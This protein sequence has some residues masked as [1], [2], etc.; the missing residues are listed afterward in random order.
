[1][2]GLTPARFVAKTLEEIRSELEADYRAALGAGVDT[3]AESVRTRWPIPMRECCA[4]DCA[5]CAAV[6]VAQRVARAA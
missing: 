5:R 6:V 2:A 1:M 3:S 4:A